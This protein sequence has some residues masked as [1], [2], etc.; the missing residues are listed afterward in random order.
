MKTLSSAKRWWPMGLVALVA[1]LSLFAV[2]HGITLAQADPHPGLPATPV[3]VPDL[4]LTP[5]S[6][7]NVVGQT[8]TVTANRTFACT[9]LPDRLLIF[10]VLSGPTS[11]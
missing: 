11:G 2:N 6:A 8:H 3:I 1:V 4:T 7:V 5:A 10:T 9:F